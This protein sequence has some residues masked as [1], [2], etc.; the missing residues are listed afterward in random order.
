VLNWDQ[1]QIPQ[2]DLRQIEDQITETEVW[3]AIF[4]APLEK[5]PGPDGYTGL[6]YKLTWQIIKEDL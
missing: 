3:A 4:S 2:H 5:A 6:F 1:L